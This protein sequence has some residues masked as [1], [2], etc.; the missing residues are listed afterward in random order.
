[1][2]STS[3]ELDKNDQMNT[4]IRWDNGRS[5]MGGD[6]R[7]SSGPTGYQPSELAIRSLST[8]AMENLALENGYLWYLQ[9]FGACDFMST[10]FA[11]K[12]AHHDFFDMTHVSSTIRSSG[13]S[14]NFHRLCG[15]GRFC[16]LRNAQECVGQAWAT[17]GSASWLQSG[18]PN[19]GPCRLKFGQTWSV[20]VM[21]WPALTVAIASTFDCLLEAC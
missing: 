16:W 21:L 8:L 18:W 11:K 17:K 15:G 19:L 14:G 12:W 4:N 1:M 20:V 10:L 5:A 7:V 9:M 6:G 3:M 13:F 2:F